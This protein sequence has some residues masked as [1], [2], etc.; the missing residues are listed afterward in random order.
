MSLSGQNTKCQHGDWQPVPVFRPCTLKEAEI[1]NIGVLIIR[2]GFGDPLYHNYNKEPPQK[3]IGTLLRPL[4][5]GLGF[6]LPDEKRRKQSSH[7]AKLLHPVG[8]ALKIFVA[9]LFRGPKP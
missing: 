4:Y 2:I 3:S 8:K 1:G 9:W 5:Y 7:T 6:R